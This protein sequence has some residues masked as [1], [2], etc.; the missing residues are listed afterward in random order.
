MSRRVLIAF[1]VCFGLLV[2]ATFG[3]SSTFTVE[4]KQ[5]VKAAPELVF[6][7]VNDLHRWPEWSPWESY[8]PQVK[9]AFGGSAFGVGATH[10]WSG[11]DAIGEGTMS[12]TESTPP[13]KVSLSVTFARPKSEPA[14]LSFTL[15]PGPF[16]TE[17]VWRY[18]GHHTLGEKIAA[19]V[20]SPEGIMSPALELGLSNLK[21][22]AEQQAAV[23]PPAPVPAEP[24]AGAP[25]DTSPDAGPA[26]P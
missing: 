7:L 25:A 13:S 5:L 8:D 12:I 9:H 19:R 26:A 6:P 11:T 22:L 4:K 3:R 2:L 17:V 18:T 1:A 24:D 10:T 14:E 16:G 15:T 20:V 23:P 21:R